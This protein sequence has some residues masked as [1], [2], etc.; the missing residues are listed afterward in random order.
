[1]TRTG[2]LLAGGALS[3][4]LWF[5]LALAFDKGV[6]DFN[7]PVVPAASLPEIAASLVSA[8]VAG[9]AVAFA[10]SKA[11]GHRSHI[12]LYLTPIGALAVGVCAFS[13]FTWV[14]GQVVGAAVQ[15]LAVILGTLSS[16]AMLSAFTPILY[17]LAL[18]NGL[19]LGKLVRRA[20]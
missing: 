20:A 12:V 13:V 1:M 15:G 7:I 18:V 14:L 9:V 11:W 5:F 10:F 6:R 17:V 16:Y 2:R 3:G 8:A 19:A 4:I